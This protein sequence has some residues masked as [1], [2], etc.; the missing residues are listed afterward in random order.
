MMQAARMDNPNRTS[1]P[2]I[3]NCW[4]RWAL[5]TFGWLNVIVAL[6]GVIVPGLPTTIFLIV[7]FWAFSNSSEKFQNW[8]W[9]HPKF[10]PS[11]RHWHNH[12]VI[13]LKAK[14]LAVTMMSLSFCYVTF[15]YA[16]SL[17]IPVVMAVVMVPSGIY[18]V[19]RASLPPEDS[20]VPV[21][22]ANEEPK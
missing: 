22:V 19:S 4:A 20:Q 11:I 17:I 12:R 8:I 16:E 15:F 21:P 13:P 7:A 2:K 6:I 1:N 10:G 14:I 3:T 18:V 5:I 9:N